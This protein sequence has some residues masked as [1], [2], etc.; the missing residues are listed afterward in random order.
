MVVGDTHAGPDPAISG[1]L[2]TVPPPT[3]S[4]QPVVVAELDVCKAEDADLRLYKPVIY[5]ALL[6]DLVNNVFWH[7]HMLPFG[8]YFYTDVPSDTNH[9]GWTDWKAGLIPVSGGRLYINPFSVTYADIV[10]MAVSAPYL[11]RFKEFVRSLLYILQREGEERGEG[12]ACNILRYYARKGYHTDRAFR[13]FIT[14][15]RYLHLLGSVYLLNRA[16]MENNSENQ[17]V[18]TET[19]LNSLQNHWD[20]LITIL[21]L[22]QVKEEIEERLSYFIVREVK[23]RRGISI[24]LIRANAAKCTRLPC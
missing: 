1:K 22:S 14:M 20:S 17:G 16:C 21:K 10:N 19:E 18:G 4:G 3:G 15:E 11:H 9:R 12:G 2:I 7:R 24:R 6:F 13:K 8:C 5:N 23:N